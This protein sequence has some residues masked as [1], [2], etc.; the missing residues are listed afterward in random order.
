V[1]GETAPRQARDVVAAHVREL[2]DRHGIEALVVGAG[3]RAGPLDVAIATDWRAA[4][5]L[6]HYDAAARAWL[7]QDLEDRRDGEPAR[8]ALELPLPLIAGARWIAALLDRLRPRARTALVRPGVEKP[9]DPAQ[10]AQRRAGPLRVLVVGDPSEPSEGVAEALSA[11]GGMREERIASLLC[12]RP[13]AAAAGAD[14]VLGPQHASALFA[15]SDVVLHMARVDGLPLAPLH[16]FHH[17][18]TSVMCPVTGHDEYLVDG[19][20]GAT[21]SFDDERGAARAL[22]LLAR[23]RAY[24]AFLRQN[25]LATARSWPSWQQATTMM[26]L[27]LRRIQRSTSREQTWLG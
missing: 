11:A 13:E 18:A 15:D 17:G 2:R 9:A 27:A 16:G 5:A 12:P 6:E 23:D 1:A 26:A 10:P 24:L 21:V 14:R 4:R 3:E 19:L 8:A 20:N 22:D 7:I 25:A